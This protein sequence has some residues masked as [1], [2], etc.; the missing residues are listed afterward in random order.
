M[1][2]KHAFLRRLTIA[3][4]IAWTLTIPVLSL[5]PPERIPEGGWFSRLPHADKWIHA[6]IYGVHTMLM[7]VACRAFRPGSRPRVWAGLALASC[8]YGLLME[9]LQLALTESR[10]FSWGDATV[11]AAGAL[12]AL[13]LAFARQ[14]S[15]RMASRGAGWDAT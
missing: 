4:A 10:S 8:L 5:V 3:A 11:N 14:G 9:A 6:A 7:I 12:L 1:S 2:R 15:R 13:G